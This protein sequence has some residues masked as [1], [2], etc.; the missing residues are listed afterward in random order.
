MEGQSTWYVKEK[1]IYTR[2]TNTAYYCVTYYKC[3][4]H[5]FPF[6][7]TQI[8]DPYLNTTISANPNEVERVP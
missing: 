3:P 4:S 2:E 7:A 1:E 5:P 8:I 6:N